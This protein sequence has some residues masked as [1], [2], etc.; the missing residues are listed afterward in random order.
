MSDSVDGGPTITV[1]A[2]DLRASR[3]SGRGLRK[4]RLAIVSTAP[5]RPLL[6]VRTRSQSHLVRTVRGDGSVEVVIDELMSSACTPEHADWV[7]GRARRSLP[8]W[9]V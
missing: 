6:L 2:D 3:A 9:V 7:R 5:A 8:E 1:A 4:S